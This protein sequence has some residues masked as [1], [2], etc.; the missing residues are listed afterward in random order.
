LNNFKEK[1]SA[2]VK[3]LVEA[4]EN[5]PAENWLE[6]I[7]KKRQHLLIAGIALI[8]VSQS[9]YYLMPASISSE[10][11]RADA[12]GF[13]HWWAQEFVYHYYYNDLFPLATRAKQKEFSEE[14][15]RVN[16]NEK[17]DS[18]MT[19]YRHW[20][21]FG[22]SAR[23]WLYLPY[24]SITQSAENP[25]IR[26]TN[27]LFLTLVL[28]YLYV[29]FWKRRMSFLGL[30]LVLI[31]GSAPFIVYETHV[32]NNIFGLMAA[33]AVLL[34]V[35]YLPLFKGNFKHKYIV[36]PLVTGLL[37]GTIYHIRAESTAMLFSPLIIVWLNR[38]IKFL[39]SLIITAVL[40]CSFFLTRSMIKEHFA[41]L[42]AETNQLVKDLGG[43]PFEGGKTLV[44]PL[45]HPLYCG[46]GDFD[47]EYGHTLHDTAVF[48][49]VLPI[50]R[51]RTGEE[52]KYP[53]NTIYE[54]AEFYDEDSLYY[55]YVAT[56]P[57]FDQIV[58]EL[59]ITDIK[60]D[61]LWYLGILVKRTQKFFFHLSPMGISLKDRVIPLPFHGIIVLLFGF[62]LF[63]YKKWFWL[64]LMFFTLPL[65][66]SVIAVFY[67]WNNSYQSIFHL[68]SFSIL[69]YG[70]VGYLMKQKRIKTSQ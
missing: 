7:F 28:T 33:Y 8:V 14:G 19:E 1:L 16:L 24:A 36:I 2:F 23:I 49:F 48:N 10:Y 22:E 6:G 44:H 62:I 39:Q 60:N 15:A 4:L 66:V 56:I 20:A 26:F 13:N 69:A 5:N 40:L 54:M 38:N 18:L 64:K 61:P 46:L 59:F 65:G 47:T 53:G 29:L 17:P 70:L 3:G 11:R 12:T 67:G 9:L 35:L 63:R 52:L 34:T 30:I 21:R 50:L 55:K 45:W 51:E 58:K 41:E 43:T 42:K 32:N 68:F 37:A 25:Q 31:I 57:G 27:F